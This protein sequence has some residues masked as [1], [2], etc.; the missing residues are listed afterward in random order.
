M[1]SLGVCRWSGRITRFSAFAHIVG[2]NV[3][4]RV[5]SAY[6]LHVRAE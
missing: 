2:G 5:E 4:F 1:M 3:R 6:F